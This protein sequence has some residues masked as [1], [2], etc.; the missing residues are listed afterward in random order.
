MTQR[1]NSDLVAGV[2]GAIVFAVFWFNRGTMTPLSGAFPDAVLVVMLAVSVAL[3]VK[4]V[5]SADIRPA[6]PDGNVGRVTTM[7]AGLGLWWLGIRYVGFLVTSTTM[8]FVIA[9]SLAAAVETLS[10]R[11]AL[12]FAAVAIAIVGGLYL[13]FTQ[14]LHI[15]PFRNPLP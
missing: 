12:F 3:L 9:L 4:G 13:V 14:V 8:F 1:I 5:I 10:L 6:F 15:R 7:I 2:L 11:R